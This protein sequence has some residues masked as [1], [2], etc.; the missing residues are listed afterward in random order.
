MKFQFQM[1]YSSLQPLMVVSVCLVF[2]PFF[3]RNALN[4][5]PLLFFSSSAGYRIEH[6]GCRGVKRDEDEG[7]LEG[8]V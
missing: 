7:G 5:P 4:L 3:C 8:E 6:R 1:S 2:S